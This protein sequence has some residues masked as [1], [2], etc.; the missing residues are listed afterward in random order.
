MLSATRDL[1]PAT[2]LVVSAGVSHT[3]REKGRERDREGGEREGL[4]EVGVGR[5]R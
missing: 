1:P 5:G 4:L 3:E 2:E